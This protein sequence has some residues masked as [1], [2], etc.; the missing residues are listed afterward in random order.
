M[1][2]RLYLNACKYNIQKSKTAVK[3]YCRSLFVLL[4]LAIVLSILLRNT[5]TDYPLGIVKLFLLKRVEGI[6]VLVVLKDVTF[7][8]TIYSA[9]VN[10]D[11]S[12]L[13]HKYMYLRFGEIFQQYVSPVVVFSL[14]GGR[15]RSTRRK[16]NLPVASH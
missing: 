14:I 3:S 15:I 16:N 5:D 6:V 7:I 13:N 4:I 11:S 12:S 2:S 1:T 8:V 9:I 10:I